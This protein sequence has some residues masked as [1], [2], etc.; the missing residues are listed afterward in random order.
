MKKSDNIKK[1][2]INKQQSFSGNPLVTRDLPLMFHETTKLADIN[3]ADPANAYQAGFIT[4]VKDGV[5]TD[6]E[7]T[8]DKITLSGDITF[9]NKIIIS[10]SGS[11]YIISTI[12]IITR[13]TLPP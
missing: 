13:S 1:N 10:K 6:I 5:K 11:E 7:L 12:R 4:V 3:V 2:T 9:E 8:A